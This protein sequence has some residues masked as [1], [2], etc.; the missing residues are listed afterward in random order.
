MPLPFGNNAP[1]LHRFEVGLSARRLRKVHVAVSGREPRRQLD[2]PVLDMHAAPKRVVSAQDQR[3]HALLDDASNQELQ[4]FLV[5]GDGIRAD[6]VVVANP[7]R[8]DRRSR[9]I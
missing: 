8:V 6:D 5:P 7:A 2:R 3:P 4:E 1:E 9:T